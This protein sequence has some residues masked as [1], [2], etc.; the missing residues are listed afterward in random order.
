MQEVSTTTKS[1]S[2]SFPKRQPSSVYYFEDGLRCVEPYY[3]EFTSYVKG[4]WVGRT[5]MDIYT[6]E[7][8]FYNEQY[9]K[10][11]I[12]LQRFFL[13]GK[14]V[15]N[16]NLKLKNLQQISHKVHRHELPVLDCDIEFLRCDD[17]YV[18][19]NKPHSIPIHPCGR[20]RENTILHILKHE[21][22]LSQ[23]FRFVYSF[24]ELNFVSHFIFCS[25]LSLGSIDEWSI[26]NGEK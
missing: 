13:D 20:Y 7:F 10:K 26:D 25:M 12:E 19:I 6:K 18:V 21:Y 4:R 9:V 2:S 15:T 16:P 3:F 22:N 23:L 8:Q 1:N 17:D 24:C 11:G 5:V 14:V